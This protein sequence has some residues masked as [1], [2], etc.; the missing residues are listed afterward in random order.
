MNQD[1]YTF[2]MLFSKTEC[3]T[4]EMLVKYA[5]GL[6]S[7]DEARKVELHLVDCPLCDEALEGILLCGTQAYTDLVNEVS[8]KVEALEKDT[9]HE[10][11]KVI[12]FRPNINP[13]HSQTQPAATRGNGGFRKFL[14]FISIAASVALIVTLGILFLGGTSAGKIADSYFEAYNEAGTRGIEEGPADVFDQG[15][16]AYEAK[17]FLTAASFFDKDQSSKAAFLAGD[18]YY[19]AGKYDLAVIRYKKVIDANQGHEEVAEFNLAMTYLKMDEVAQATMVL[20]RITGDPNHDY[21]KDAQKALDE[22]IGL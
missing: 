16:T 15:M 4:Q 12:E 17:D 14:P 6:L 19:Q 2:D 8:E 22:V 3:I 18:S 7:P 10:K 1:R 9:E 5:D 21:Y 13:P 20:K 11:G